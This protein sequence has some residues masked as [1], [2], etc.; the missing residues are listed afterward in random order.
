MQKEVNIIK[1]RLEEAIENREAIT[2]QPW[3]YKILSESGT[4]ILWL[5][6]ESQLFRVFSSNSLKND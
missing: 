2:M 1:Y 3:S 5:I 4:Y 6:L